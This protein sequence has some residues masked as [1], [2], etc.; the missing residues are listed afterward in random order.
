M[1]HFTHNDLDAL[2]CMLC[3]NTRYNNISKTYHTYYGDFSEQVQNILNDDDQHVMIT[4]LCFSDHKDDLIKLIENKKAV[5]LFDH[6]SYPESFFAD[7]DTKP[8]FRRFINTAH[9]ASAECFDKFKIDNDNLKFLIRMINIYDTWKQNDEL[10]YNAQRLN[11][12]FWT[13]NIS[14]LSQYLINN[15]YCLPS[16]YLP[17][18]QKIVDDDLE[19]MNEVEKA[20][21]KRCGCV[22]FVFSHT[23]FNDI[24]IQQHKFR[25]AFV[26]GIYN[27]I[28][29]VRVNQDWDF[30][31]DDLNE[32]R[33]KVMGQIYGHPHAFTYKHEGDLTEECKRLG[34]LLNNF[35]QEH[36]CL[37]F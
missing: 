31:E 4:D 18:S 13:K 27:N 36:P 23:C 33:M 19:K 34:I 9:C 2:G 29:K 28:Y 11:K 6:H 17:S 30:S 26:I 32:L 8:N 1:I 10:F 25:Q 14:E 21:L 16:N 20:C 15:D 24:V 5:I 37:P 3:V 12:W 7:L 35:V 22:S